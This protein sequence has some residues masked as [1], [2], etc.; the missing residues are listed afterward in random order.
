ML[1]SQIHSLVS[2]GGVYYSIYDKINAPADFIKEIRTHDTM[3]IVLY[4]DDSV[5]DLMGEILGIECRLSKY[6][7]M[8]PFKCYAG[9]MFDQFNARQIQTIILATL[10]TEMDIEYLQKSGVI[11]HHFP[12]HMPERELIYPSWL[13]YRWRLSA[14]MISGSFVKNMQPI[15]LIKNYYGEKFGFYFAWLVHYTGW[16]IPAAIVGTVFGIYMIVEAV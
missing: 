13:D 2:R 3:I 10:E 12:V 15:N 14:G 1:L 11:L 4:F 6:D 9:D 5:I 8:L 16:L 7:C